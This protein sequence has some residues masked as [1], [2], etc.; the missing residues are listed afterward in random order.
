MDITK[1]ITH[2][3]LC[4]GYGGLGLGLKRV[5]PELRDVAHVEIEAFACANLVAKMES[6]EMDP[7]PIWT[8]L[9][10]FD[11]G[12]FRGKVDIMSG[13]YPCQPFSVAGKRG[14]KADPRHLWPYIAKG[15]RAARPAICFFENVEG[16]L[17]AG[18]KEV[19]QSLRRLG[20]AVEAGV[21][22]AAEIGAPHQRKRVFILGVED[23]RISR[24]RDYFS[25][26]DWQEIVRSDDREECSVR[27]E[28]ASCELSNSASQRG[29]KVPTQGRESS[30]QESI[31]NG[32]KWPA[33]PNE[34]QY[35]WERNRVYID[36]EA[37]YRLLKRVQAR[38]AQGLPEGAHN[39]IAEY[40]LCAAE[41]SLGG[42]TDGFRGRVDELRLLGNGVM[43]DVAEV[44][45][46]ELLGK[47]E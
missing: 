15:I 23:S 7:A 4:S 36:D 34:K 18:F 29:G 20:Y 39:A 25:G 2:V 5:L 41:S 8:D 47:F 45:F 17:S 3:S 46:V 12:A 16:H 33:R 1:A 6:G 32:K 40:E 21:F 28:S 37:T 14:G 11:F 43:P 35:E 44:A 38:C 22:S 10:T 27:A 26:G 24:V 13:G 9:K 31:S 42:A 30:S 19:Q